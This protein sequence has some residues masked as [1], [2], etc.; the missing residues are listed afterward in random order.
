ML[1]RSDWQVLPAVTLIAYGAGAALQRMRDGPARFWLFLVALCAL[2]TPLLFF[3]YLAPL[4]NFVVP[5]LPNVN[6]G[7]VVASPLLPIGLSFYTFLGIGYVIDVYVGNAEA[8]KSA[9]NFAAMMSFFP[10]VTSGPIER[11]PHFLLQ[12]TKLGRP[13]Y[14]MAVSGLRALLLGLVFKVVVADSLSPH[15]NLVF[16]DPGSFGATDLALANL[17]F[18]FQVYADFA[19]YSLIAIGSARLFGVELLP[20][21]RQP[22][23]SE[24]LSEF[25][26]RWHISLSSW[27]RDYVFTPLQFKTR[28]AGTAGIA[29]ALT[30]S[31]VLVGIWH[32]AGLKYLLFGL[33]HG[34]LVAGSTLTLAA[35]N[36]FWKRMGLP[37]AP[38]R[39]TRIVVTFAIVYL[40]LILFRSSDL[41]AALHYYRGMI[42]GFRPGKLPFALPMMLIVLALAIDISRELG[43]PLPKNPA[44]R[45]VGYYLVAVVFIGFTILNLARGNGDGQFIYFNF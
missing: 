28:R 37:Y 22:Y 21:F 31:F 6:S 27:F 40:T 35:R 16:G 13:S 42:Q 17:Y 29:A 18:A 19:G 4:W 24:T 30:L 1:L 5:Q 34:V 3:K 45:W 26:R 38:L 32:G 9:L 10:T 7:L 39:V 14:E 23:F 2:L 25:W 20:N 12:L 43:W 8:E 44:V 36:R 33:V 11:A 41:N 15:V